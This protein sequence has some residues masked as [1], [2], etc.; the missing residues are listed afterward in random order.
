MSEKPSRP[1]LFSLALIFLFGGMLFNFPQFSFAQL[2]ESISAPE[3]TAL[4]ADLGTGK[5]VLTGQDGHYIGKIL[6]NTSVAKAWKVLTDYSNFPKFLPSVTSIKILEIT[7]NTKVYEQ[8][9][10]VQV[11][12][13][14]QTSKVTIAATEVNPS[15]ITFQMRAGESI[16]SL[17]GSWQI[18]AIAPNQ[19]LITNLV[20]VEPSASTPSSLFYSIYRESLIKTL[21]ALKQETERRDSLQN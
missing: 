6:I 14:S 19:V 13:F 12:F 1:A 7:G 11:L 4:N 16:K 15:L 2:A 8:T 21:T 20:N 9:N 3:Q 10:V 5:A 18:E 17:K